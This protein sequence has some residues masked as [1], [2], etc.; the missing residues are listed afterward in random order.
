VI[1]AG[2][3]LADLQRLLKILENDLRQRCQDNADVNARVLAEYNKA[4][5]AGRTSQAYQVWRDEFI[6]QV[7]VSWIL[8]CVFV[9][10]IEDNQMLDDAQTARV[11]LAGP[12]ERLQL[13][14]DQH[15]VYFREHPAESDREYL[16]HVF[17]AVANPTGRRPIPVV[18][19]LFD[20]AHNPLW[21]LGVSGDGAT[22]LLNFWQQIEPEKGTLKHD[23]TDENWNTRF[24]G[25]LYQ[26]LSEAA[27]KKYALLQT[28]VFVEEFILDRTLTP[29]INEFGYQVVRLIDPA[30]GSGHFLLGAFERLFDLWVRNQPGVNAPELARRALAQ[31]H[32]VDLNPF[33]VAIARFRLLVAALKASGI[34]RLQDAPAF[35]FNLA[36]GDSLLHGPARGNGA[37]D[38]LNMMWSPMAHVY[39]TEDKTQ[40]NQ[41]LLPGRYHAVV[42]NPPYIT[43]KD[44]ALNKAYR[45]R[46]GS[47][48]MK[49]SLA[50][51]FME[52]FFDL[53]IKGSNDNSSGY[54]GMITSNSF[55]KREFGKKLIEHYI[56]RWNLTQ[57]VDTSGA[58]IPGHATPTVILFGRNQNPLAETIRTVMGIK[59]EPSTPADPAQGKVWVSIVE[60]IDLPGTQTDFVSVGDPIRANFHKHPW[61]I[62]GGGAAELKEILDRRAGKT[63]S[64]FVIS[65]GFGAILGE[66]D[67]FSVP[68]NVPSI[69]K[70]PEDLRRPVVEG[71]LIRDWRLSPVLEALFP[72]NIDIELK[73]ESIIKDWLWPL[74]TMLWARADFS[75][76]TFKECERPY[77]EFHQIPKERNRTPFCISFAAVATH[78]HFVLDRGGKIFKQSAPILKLSSSATETDHYVVLGI[79]NSSTAC[80]WMKQVFYPKGTATGDISREKGKPES[81]RYDFAATG[82]LSFP[83]PIALG[84]L[85]VLADITKAIDSTA[86]SLLRVE[87]NQVIKDW[88]L[89]K[90]GNALKDLL[91]EATETYNKTKSRMVI[92]QEELDWEVYKQFNLI[93]KGAQSNVLR[94]PFIAI[95]P[96]D[97]PAFWPNEEPPD[98]LPRELVEIYAE[99]RQILRSNINVS[100]IETPVFKRLWLGQQGVFGHMTAT[101]AD[102]ITEALKNWLTNRLEGPRFWAREEL[103]TTARLADRVRTDKEFM[104]VAEMYRG[105]SD[106][107]VANLIAELAKSEAVPFLP[108]LRYKPSGLRNR[109]IWE[110]VWEMQRQEDAIDARS[111]L[112][113]DDPQRLTEDEAKRLKAEQIGD[114]PVPPKY[115]STDFLEGAFWRLRGKLD[116]PKERFISYPGCERDADPSLVIAWAGWDHLQQAKALAAYYEQMKTNEGWGPARLVPLLAGIVELLPWLMQWHNEIDPAYGIG[117]GDF[118][119]S[120]VE[121]EARALG[122]T[123]NKIREWTPSD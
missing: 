109:Q 121:E 97:R 13:A 86:Q 62:G 26:E 118:F 56:P 84:S 50:V 27:R 103:A 102:R 55:M 8:G 43:P 120:F 90:T 51:P 85:E 23:F 39:E 2:Q 78:N 40:L 14:R 4:K 94:D 63:L 61:N 93:E 89:R 64:D 107:D 70:I 108:V 25:D 110:Q 83:I 6:T 106:F 82:L 28:P 66:D 3:L 80:F 30:C 29:A 24:L 71:E 116:V 115:R 76:R 52:R 60:S 31:V 96:N 5:A 114:I 68:L 81:N 123:L 48:H 72:Y 22:A 112:S 57:V 32:G 17:R 1:D 11:W 12:R 100:I 69:A 117:M 99:R 9:R 33:A 65:G 20:E 10:F 88:E 38:Q 35:E 53:A 58:Y 122:L 104:Q 7:A 113:K 46:F 59:G 44:A 36:V 77:W 119:K 91:V 34:E 37:G 16:E 105:R 67:A 21:R 45:G 111:K 54:V 15:T 98:S 42:G 74:R 87:P 47:C 75:K 92:L 73:D 79:L 49:Y 101:Y 95:T 41:I 18:R 19:A